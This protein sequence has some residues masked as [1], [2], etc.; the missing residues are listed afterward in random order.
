MSYRIISADCH[1]DMTWMPGTLTLWTENA[2][3]KLR[4]HVP[5]VRETP[6]DPKWYAEGKELDAIDAEVMYGLLGIGM[7]LT[8]AEL[9]Q[10]VFAIYN[11]WA[12]DFCKTNPK[13]FVGLACIPN[14]DPQAAATE[15]RR[16][17]TLGLKGADF[18]VSTAVSAQRPEGDRRPLS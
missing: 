17:A 3:A 18:A 8:D 4:E 10:A 11:D 12:A 9:R 7:R 14:H 2:P 15:L 6:E 13:R 1:I 5:Q 16:A